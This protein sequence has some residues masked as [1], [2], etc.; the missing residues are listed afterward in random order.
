MIFKYKQK[1]TKNANYHFMENIVRVLSKLD[2]HSNQRM[3]TRNLKVILEIDVHS[4][5]TMPFITSCLF[6]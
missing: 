1:E 4:Y 6:K 3:P 2:K 5:R